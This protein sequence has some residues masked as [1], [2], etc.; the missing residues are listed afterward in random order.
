MI[1]LTASTGKLAKPAAFYIPISLDLN[2]YPPEWRNYICYFLNL[3]HWKS[4]CCWRADEFGYVSLKYDYLTKVIPK[5]FYRKIRGRLESDGVIECDGI[6]IKGEKALGYKTL[7]PY[8]KARRVV[9][10]DNELSKKIARLYAK[11]SAPK[12]PVHNWLEDKLAMLDFDLQLAESIILTMCPEEGSV[13]STQEYRR[14]LW[15][16]VQKFAD[17]EHYLKV[18]AYGRVHTL[19]TSLPKALRPCLRVGGRYLVGIDLVNSQPLFA[20]LLARQFYSSHSRKSRLSVK[21]FDTDKTPYCFRS[22]EDVRR[23]ESQAQLAYGGCFDRRTNTYIPSQTPPTN[24]ITTVGN[25]PSAV[26]ANTY[27]TKQLQGL[28]QADSTNLAKY[29]DLCERGQ[30]YEHLKLP[31]EERSSFKKLLY[32]NVF[33]G[34]N[35]IH[36]GLKERFAVEFPVVADMF[37]RLKA[38]DYRRCSWLL[39]N[40]EATV[41]IWCICRRIQDERPTL[42][43]FTIHDSILTIPEMCS[44][45][46]AVIVDEF[47]K[48]GFS[49]KLRKEAYIHCR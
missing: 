17:R 26:A 41:F 47:R 7:E 13:L 11:N 21:E 33:F 9:C 35:D 6:Y 44:N 20:G 32:Q 46:E 18:D 38:R 23:R 45:I 43:I 36:S 27:A 16:N 5:E 14:R 25:V 2:C 15:N 12:S 19:I 39:Q 30:I 29:I 1:Q 31:G 28:S 8:L 24:P 37:V 42:P 4:Q 49:P 3:I 10:Q 34:K 48:L 22:M 40:Y